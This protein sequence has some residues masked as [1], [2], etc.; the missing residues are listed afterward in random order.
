VLWQLLCPRFFVA[1]CAVAAT[2]SQGHAVNSTRCAGQFGGG[3]FGGPGGGEGPLTG[4]P[5]LGGGQAGGT[6]VGSAG[7]RGS[8]TQ[9]ACPSPVLTGSARLLP[10]LDGIPEMPGNAVYG[11]P[12]TYCGKESRHVEQCSPQASCLCNILWTCTGTPAARSRRQMRAQIHRR[13]RSATP[14]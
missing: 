12:T 2:L 11:V 3:F 4:T 9:C 8:G 5:N 10:L 14:A 7:T 13:S 6:L 1:N